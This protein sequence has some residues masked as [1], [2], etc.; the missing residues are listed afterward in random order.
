MTI[1]SPRG[2]GAITV[3]GERGG[4]GQTHAET[5]GE[6]LVV[7]CPRCE[8]VIM[9]LG[10]GYGASPQSA[11]LTPDEEAALEGTARDRAEMVY[12]MASAM[13]QQ[14]AAMLAGGIAPARPKPA[15]RKRTQARP[16]ADQS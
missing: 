10:L 11:A 8:P 15:P 5:D 4:C 16:A 2:S 7:D 6:R 9:S 14:G 12:A 13:A 1:Y 3:P